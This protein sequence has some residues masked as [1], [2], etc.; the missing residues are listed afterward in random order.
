MKVFRWMLIGVVGLLGMEALAG[1][2][3][4][5]KSKSVVCQACH[6]LDGNSPLAMYP[7]IAGQQESYLVTQITA[8]R[9]KKRNDPLM[10]PMVANLSDQDIED[11]AAY[12][13]GQAIKHGAVSKDLLDLGQQVY[14]GGNLDSSVPACM[15]CHG[16]KGVGNGP[17]GWPALAGQYPEYVVKQ[18]RAYAKG[19]RT[20]D[21]NDMMSDIA[22]RLND[23]E[24]EAVANYVAGLH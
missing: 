8:F 23:A 9:D 11:L 1:D 4:A 16:P 10:A 15:S 3:E 5:G 24:I 14:R 18:L 2:A 12:F 6:A 21:P 19:E 13:A 20:G 7:K 17:A 22:A